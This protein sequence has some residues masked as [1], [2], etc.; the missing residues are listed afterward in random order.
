MYLTKK[1]FLIIVFISLNS[2]SV[3]L[4][5]VPAFLDFK[6]ILNQSDAGKKA[7]SF[8]K[9][10]LNNGIKNLQNKEKKIQEEEKKINQQKKIISAEDYKK[11]VNNLRN[12]VSLLQ[13]ERNALLGNVAKQ[14]S[15][16]RN[17]LLKTLNPILK[18]YM[19][20]K[21]IKMVIDKKNILLADDELNITK[22]I[23]VLLN[24]K[25]KSIDLK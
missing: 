2:N 10:K 5:D 22:D 25:L 24:K 13:K 21:N 9:S 8:L 17:D 11:Q 3:A 16:A 7:Q 6:F 1:L 12:K 23:M 20:E 19:V 15:K 18:D 14:R 4:S